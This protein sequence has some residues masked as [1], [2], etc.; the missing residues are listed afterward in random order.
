[1]SNSWKG[2]VADNIKP[3]ESD[4]KI[5]CEVVVWSSQLDSQV[6]EGKGGWVHLLKQGRT[7]EGSR[8]VV[9]R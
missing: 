1:M 3:L 6:D 9:S 2:D 4:D 8:L 5:L 7:K